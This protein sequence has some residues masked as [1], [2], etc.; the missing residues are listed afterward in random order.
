MGPKH[1]ISATNGFGIVQEGKVMRMS[2]K[3]VY[4]RGT[5]YW[6]TPEGRFEKVEYADGRPMERLYMRT[7]MGLM[8]LSGVTGIRA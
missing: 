1:R 7:S 3:L 5:P 8:A 6:M 4:M 2:N